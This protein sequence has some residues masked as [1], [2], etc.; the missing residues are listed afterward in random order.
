MAK[1]KN[2]RTGS[3]FDDWLKEEGIYEEVTTSAVKKVLA[4]KLEQAMKSQHVSKSALARRMK[5]SRAAVDRLLDPD[6]KSVTLNTIA[7]AAA[8]LGKRID[9]E[10]IDA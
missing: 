9:I 6:N 1:K 7:R 8:T 10:F 5:T 3:S 2:P 4:W